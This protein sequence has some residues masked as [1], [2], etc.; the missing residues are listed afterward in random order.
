MG[1]A[2]ILQEY[3][4]ASRIGQLTKR[5]MYKERMVSNHIQNIKFSRFA[6]Y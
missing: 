5:G 3:N 1:V 6:L 4:H 2:K